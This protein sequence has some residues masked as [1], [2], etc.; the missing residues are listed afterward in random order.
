MTFLAKMKRKFGTECEYFYNFFTISQNMSTHDWS[1]IH[2]LKKKKKK[3]KLTLFN[4]I[5]HI[6]TNRE[7]YHFS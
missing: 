3:K 2:H 5:G 1:N 4:H 6:L 7:T